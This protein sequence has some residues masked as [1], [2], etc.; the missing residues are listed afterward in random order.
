[1]WFLIVEIASVL[2]GLVVII[3][4]QILVWLVGINHIQIGGYPTIRYLAG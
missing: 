1:V 3:K 2:P 4:L